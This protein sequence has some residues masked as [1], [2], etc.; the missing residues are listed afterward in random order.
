MFSKVFTKKLSICYTKKFNASVVSTC[1]IFKFVFC[2]LFREYFCDTSKC[3]QLR[4]RFGEPGAQGFA[5]V[6]R[7]RNEVAEGEDGLDDLKS[8]WEDDLIDRAGNLVRRNRD[9]IQ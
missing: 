7:R 5:N 6:M 1:L 2:E 8:A 4:P 9:S 3:I